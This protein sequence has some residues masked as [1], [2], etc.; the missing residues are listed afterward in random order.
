MAQ[1]AQVELMKAQAE[2]A[3]AEADSIRGVEGTK[4]ATEIKEGQTRIESLTQGINNQRAV[5]QLTRAETELKEIDGM[6]QGG[7][8]TL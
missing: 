7:T 1:A 5:E 6:V 8:I 2:K 3:K 4:G